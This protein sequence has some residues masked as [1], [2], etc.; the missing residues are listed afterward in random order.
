MVRKFGSGGTM[1]LVLVLAVVAYLAICA[2]AIS[3]L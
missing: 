2:Y 1:V 3:K